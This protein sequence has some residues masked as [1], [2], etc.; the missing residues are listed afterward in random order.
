[1]KKNDLFNLANNKLYILKVLELYG[2]DMS[3]KNLLHLVLTKEKMNY[4]FCMQYIQ[5]LEQTHLI[6]KSEDIIGLTDLGKDSLNWFG[7]Q[8]SEEEVQEIETFISSIALSDQEYEF[9]ENEDFYTLQVK[10]DS[11][12]QFQLKMQKKFLS[13]ID[14]K[15]Y[16]NHKEEIIQDILNILNKE[17]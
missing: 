9:Q 14:P 3:V 7:D 2:E 17:R 8:I 6:Y 11:I 13:N 10:R 5:E 4:F 16:M 12:L 15:I 1:M